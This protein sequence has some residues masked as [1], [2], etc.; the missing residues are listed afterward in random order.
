MMT[1][2]NEMCAVCAEAHNSLNG[3]FCRKLGRYVEYER[4]SA[5][6]L[7]PDQG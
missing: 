7:T 3:R 2:T 1:D 4:T 5:P 6:C